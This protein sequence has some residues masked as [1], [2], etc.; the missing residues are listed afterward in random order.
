L[1]G[2]VNHSR[3]KGKEL[4]WTNLTYCPKACGF[5]EGVSCSREVSTERK[6]KKRTAKGKSSL[7]FQMHYLNARKE[8]NSVIEG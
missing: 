7:H 6:K 2:K 4:K 1:T 5:G 3:G 8:K